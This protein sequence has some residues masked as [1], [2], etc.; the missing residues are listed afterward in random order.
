MLKYIEMKQKYLET[1]DESLLNEI[2]NF[3]EQVINKDKNYYRKIY[4]YQ[5]SNEQLKYCI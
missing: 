4:S 2:N 1:L 3:T 5:F